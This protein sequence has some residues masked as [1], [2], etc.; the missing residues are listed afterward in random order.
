M[1]ADSR[2]S[3][4]ESPDAGLV[5]VSFRIPRWLN[6]EI[7][8]VASARASDP[9]LVNRSDIFR[10]ALEAWVKARPKSDENGEAA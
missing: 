4:D 10:E 8:E 5:T 6:D 1:P 3:G 9:R 7:T 2:N